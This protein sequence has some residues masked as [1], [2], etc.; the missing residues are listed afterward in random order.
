MKIDKFEDL[1]CKKTDHK[2]RSHRKAEI[3]AIA[4]MPQGRKYRCCICRQPGDIFILIELGPGLCCSISLGCLEKLMKDLRFSRSIA[5]SLEP[6]EIN[7]LDP[8]PLKDSEYS[9]LIESLRH[10]ARLKK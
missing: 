9:S 5:D 6:G 1:L 8:Y 3:T 4:R 10:P 7:W 2:S